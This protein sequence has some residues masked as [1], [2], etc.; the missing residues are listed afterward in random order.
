M[1]LDNNWSYSDV[2]IRKTLIHNKKSR[3]IGRDFLFHWHVLGHYNSGRYSHRGVYRKCQCPLFK[4]FTTSSMYK[5]RREGVFIVSVNVLFLSNSQPP[6]LLHRQGRGVYR[7]CQCPLFKQFTTGNLAF[8][9]ARAVFIVS[10]N[11]LFLS[12]S[13]HVYRKGTTIARCLS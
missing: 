4:Q 9:A 6:R 12:N 10:V 13:Q 7:K 1:R 3:P 8:T 11:V 5:L 2:R